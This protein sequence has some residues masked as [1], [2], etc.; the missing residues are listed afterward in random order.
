MSSATDVFGGRNV[1]VG[2][3]VPPNNAS[4]PCASCEDSDRRIKNL[5]EEV[6]RLKV[7]NKRFEMAL[8]GLGY[9]S[10]SPIFIQVTTL[11]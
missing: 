10:D 2:V 1:V 3:S 6:R 5:E 7:M 9:S 8:R 4:N 11:I